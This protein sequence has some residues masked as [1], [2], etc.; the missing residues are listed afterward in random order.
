MWTVP[1]RTGGG[2][3]RSTWRAADQSRRRSAR[4]TQ[5]GRYVTYSASV[6]EGTPPMSRDSFDYDVLVI[7]SGFGGSVAALRLTEK[8][9]RVGVL[10]AGRR[11]T[12]ETLP[13]TSWDLKNFLWA[14]QLGMR[15]IQRITLRQRRDHPVRCRGRRRLAGLRQHPLRAV[16]RLLQRPAVGAHHRL[17]GRARA[18]LRPGQAH[19]RRGREP[20][21]SPRPTMR[22]AWSPRRWASARPSARRRSGCSSVSRARRRTTRSSAA[23]GR[24]GRAACN[25][26]SA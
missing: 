8:G 15:G 19:A 23:P 21:R 25:A 3:S 10:E 5:R 9:Y 12:N 11:F 13:K 26:A 17:A 16:G 22:C 7:G 24:A 20:D 18:V 2:T 14:P 1:A 4:N 6:D